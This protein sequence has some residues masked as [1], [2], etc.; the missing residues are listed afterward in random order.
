MDT[1]H[2][3]KCDAVTVVA[4]RFA[5]HR[6]LG[7][8]HQFEPAGMRIFKFRWREGV[9]CEWPFRACLMCGLVWTHLLPEDLRTFIDENGT[10]ATKIKLS[11][12]RKS[13]PERDLN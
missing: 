4:G 3:P 12:F 2:C 11:P 6:G 5:E 9:P 8:K 10:A 7:G 13:H 1:G